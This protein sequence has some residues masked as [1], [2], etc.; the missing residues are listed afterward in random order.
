VQV[1]TGLGLLERD[2]AGGVVCPFADL[3]IDLHLRAP[4]SLAV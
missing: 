2:A 4:S 1:L 3:H